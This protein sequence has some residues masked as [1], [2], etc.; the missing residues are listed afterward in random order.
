MAKPIHAQY[1]MP[2]RREMRMSLLYR[3]V[4]HFRDQAP[5]G[6][7]NGKRTPGVVR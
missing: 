7:R 3:N 1:E 2:A 5:S 4:S 6:S